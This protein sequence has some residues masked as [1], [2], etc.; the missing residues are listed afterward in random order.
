MSV[1][2]VRMKEVLALRARVVG[3]EHAHRLHVFVLFPKR[4]AIR[5]PV[6]FVTGDNKPTNCRLH[7]CDIGIDFLEFYQHLVGMPHP[8]TG[9]SESP[10]AYPGDDT[11]RDEGQ[12]RDAKS[13]KEPRADGH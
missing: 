6:I 12:K 4:F 5:S 2:A 11:Q 8:V 1:P 9:I 10:R 7:S 3:G 13:T